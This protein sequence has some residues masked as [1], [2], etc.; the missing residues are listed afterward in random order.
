MD[1]RETPP[2]ICRSCWRGPCA[3]QLGLLS[4]PYCWEESELSGGFVYWT[5]WAALKWCQILLE[6]YNSTMAQTQIKLTT[7]FKIRVGSPRLTP[8][9]RT[10]EGA[11]LLRVY[12]YLR[13]P[14]TQRC[15]L[16]C[17]FVVYTSADDPASEYITA[18]PLLLDL[19]SPR[20]LTL[21]QECLWACV[22]SHERCRSL[23]RGTR[24]FTAP[25][26]TRL[27]DCT[28]PDRPRLLHTD[29]QCGA[30]LAL[31]YVWGETQPYRTTVANL[32]KYTDHIDP[33][34]LPQTI[35]DAI[36]VTHSLGFGSL[37]VDSLCIIQDSKEDKH[38]EMARMR[39]IYR[40]ASLTLIAASASKATEGFLQPRPAPWYARTLPFICPGGTELPDSHRK[41]HESG[42]A[43]VSTIH[44]MEDFVPWRL[45][46]PIHERG[47]CLQELLMSLRSLV[48]TSQ[49]LEFRCQT[50][51]VKVGGAYHSLHDDIQRLP[52]ILFEAEP[53]QLSPRSDDWWALWRTWR[54]V[55]KAYTRRTVTYP[56]DKLPACAGIAEEFHRVLRSDYLAGL[57][58]DTLL[59][60]LLWSRIGSSTKPRRRP[61]GYRAPSWSWAA[62]D[63][64]VYLWE[65]G[66][67]ETGHS[68]AL[69]EVVECTV[70][71]MDEAL[72]FGEF[73]AGSLVLRA[74]LVRCRCR[75][76]YN[77]GDGSP[78]N[79]G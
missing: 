55:L 4:E 62:V 49:T 43:V 11:Q 56:S 75:C 6:S 37:W 48:F 35:R 36:R 33:A 3:A 52:D 74:P 7:R 47:W 42:R 59:E 29:G 76:V 73:T 32:S 77:D 10:P 44:L 53:P 25:L 17:D 54:D 70:R 24:Q 5:S 15:Q 21:A 41:D 27:V 2:T 23:T 69:A 12:L 67:G 39:R 57:W 50:T 72:P 28:D 60:D 66:R 65:S 18:R 22:H 64:G 51:T 40:N 68:Q 14:E 61:A 38:R 20:A 26:P 63:E 34:I 58:R 30:Y 31:S 78:F 1:S 79:T 9:E 16:E 46:D 19:G 8:L 13:F 71:L 45:N